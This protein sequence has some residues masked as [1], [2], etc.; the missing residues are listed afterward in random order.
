VTARDDIQFEPLPS[1]G[2]R[3]DYTADLTLN[4]WRRLAS[5]FLGGPFRKLGENARLGMTAALAER[6]R[7]AGEASLATPIEVATPS[8][9]SSA[10]GS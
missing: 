5:P 6:A 8:N 9:E 2:T 4:G 3:V 7:A 1:G 10:T